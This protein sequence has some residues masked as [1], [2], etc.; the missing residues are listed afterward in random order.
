MI[1]LTCRQCPIAQSPNL[2]AISLIPLR[3]L[4]VSCYTRAKS[5]RLSN[6]C[7]GALDFATKSDAATR[8]EGRLHPFTLLPVLAEPIPKAY[9]PDVLM[10]NEPDGLKVGTDI[11]DL[12]DR[13]QDP[14]SN[15]PA[16]IPHLQTLISIPRISI[17]GLPHCWARVI[18]LRYT[19]LRFRSQSH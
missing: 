17:L 15:I 4:Q 5:S 13:S 8:L 14:R 10:V 16:F 7:K 11:R 18:I 3:N 1:S 6:Q 9:Y 2:R 12:R 19:Q